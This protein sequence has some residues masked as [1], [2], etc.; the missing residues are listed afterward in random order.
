MFV[1]FWVVNNVTNGENVRIP[2]NDIVKSIVKA[3]FK[4]RLFTLTF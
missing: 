3:T 2:T 1:R 4:L